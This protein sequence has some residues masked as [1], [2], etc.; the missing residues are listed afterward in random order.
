MIF[1]GQALSPQGSKLSRQYSVHYL[2]CNVFTCSQPRHAGTIDVFQY[3]CV[4]LNPAHQQWERPISFPSS[5][6]MSE[7]HLS[8]IPGENPAKYVLKITSALDNMTNFTADIYNPNHGCFGCSIA[9]GH[10]DF[11]THRNRS[12]PQ[13]VLLPPFLVKYLLVGQR[14]YFWQLKFQYTKDL[15]LENHL[16]LFNFHK[17]QSTVHW[18]FWGRLPLPVGCQVHFQRAPF[19]LLVLLFITF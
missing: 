10:I 15:L 12:A 3:A 8:E 19:A 14:Y 9:T 4:P 11:P 13:A 5:P 6:L 17:Y 7:L 16:F 1:E 18:P 2:Q